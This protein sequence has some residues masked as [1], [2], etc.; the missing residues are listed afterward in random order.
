MDSVKEVDEILATIKNNVV[1]TVKILKSWEKNLMFERKDGK[2]YTFE[3]LNDAFNQLIQQRH[4]EI[5]DGGKE[6]TK[7]LSSSNRVLKVS[8]AHASWRAYINYFSDI[9]IDGFS[10]AI[11]RTIRY[12]LTQLDPEVLTKAEGAPLL[13]IQLE[14]VQAQIV[15]KPELAEGKV[16]KSVRD[17][18][19]KVRSTRPGLRGL[20]GPMVWPTDAGWV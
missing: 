7:L 6:I 1:D 15:W 19:A 3:E 14:L 20:R 4:S 10:A 9:V 18:L 17:M 8:K 13:E 2:T 11:I 16:G 12:L 5:R